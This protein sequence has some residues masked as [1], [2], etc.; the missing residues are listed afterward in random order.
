M[1][2]ICIVIVPILG[3]SFYDSP[4]LIQ[5]NALFTNRQFGGGTAIYLTF[6]EENSQLLTEANL[7]Q[8]AQ[9][10]KERFLALGYS[11]T[12]TSVENG[13]VRVD[14]AQKEYIDSVIAEAAAPGVWSVS[15]SSMNDSLCDASM[16]EDATISTSSTGYYQVSL[17]L[18]EEGATKFAANTASYSITS[19][20]IY[21]MLDGGL[22]AYSQLNSTSAKDTVNFQVD[23]YQTAAKLVSIIKYGSLPSEV[24]IEK[25]ETTPATISGLS[26]TLVLVALAI[27]FAVACVVLL[28]KGRTAGLFAIAALIAN[29]AVL[30][31]AILNST[32]MLN[33]AT[34]ITM[35]IG[36]GLCVVLSVYSVSPIGKA[37]KENKLISTSALTKLNKINVK[38]IWIHAAIFA[39]T[40]IGW[41]LARGTYLYIVKAVMTLACSNA[42]CHFIFLYFPVCTLS[43]IQKQKADKK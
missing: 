1:H 34:L 37:L 33:L 11:D 20:Y 17:K 18:N 23:S 9:I 42:I 16:V 38:V 2:I 36:L 14:L 6:A 21:L 10:L 25:T 40:L 28:L 4:G 24:V 3:V 19:A 5:E 12:L 41:L 32:F 31:T 8:T 30:L 29:I 39:V 13:L 35:V 15:G 43:D 22:A 27:L 7:N 26:L